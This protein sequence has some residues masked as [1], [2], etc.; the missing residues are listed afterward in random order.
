[1]LRLFATEQTDLY[2]ISRSL[3]QSG[4][5]VSATTAWGSFLHDFPPADDGVV[6][7][8]P[9]LNTSLPIVS[10]RSFIREY[11][12]I[13]VILLTED[14]PENLRM[15]GYAAVREVLFLRREETLIAA[16]LH[17]ARLESIFVRS[18]DVL[19]RDHALPPALRAAILLALEQRPASAPACPDEPVCPA[20]SIRTLAR[21]LGQSEDH[22]SRLARSVDFNLRDFLD[23]CIALRGIQLH[24]GTGEGW[25]EVAWRL[26]YASTSGLS[27]QIK[28]ALGCRPKDIAQIDL[29]KWFSDFE[30]RFIHP[31]LHV[32]RKV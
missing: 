24:F 23:W 17:R 32:R 30:Q 28:H 25:E 10:L 13:P 31:L 18:A 21:R 12:W 7:V 14:H 15:L 4:F 19:R 8:V 26:G 9:W 29:E 5:D 16:G 3:E 11:P 22:L 2:R 27:E 6:M 1:M 20:R